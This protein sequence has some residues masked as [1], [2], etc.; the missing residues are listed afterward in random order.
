MT[1]EKLGIILAAQ[2]AKSPQVDEAAKTL[3]MSICDN[4]IPE[5]ATKLRLDLMKELGIEFPEDYPEAG[6]KYYEFAMAFDGDT[7]RTLSRLVGD[8]I[9]S[10]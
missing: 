6:E 2:H 4:L 3:A 7:S 1:S 10:Y 8:Y 9:D 5:L